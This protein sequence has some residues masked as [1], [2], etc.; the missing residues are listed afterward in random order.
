M[1]GRPE[2]GAKE[3]N[4][5]ILAAKGPAF[6]PFAAIDAQSSLPLYLPHNGC[7]SAHVAIGGAKADNAAS[8]IQGEKP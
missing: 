6:L 7:V 5:S 4:F 1:S 2:E 3:L 8:Q